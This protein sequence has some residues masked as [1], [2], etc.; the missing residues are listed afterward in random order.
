MTDDELISQ[1]SSWD[2]VI[3]HRA[4][5]R[6]NELVKERD[7]LR[8]FFNTNTLILGETE[9]QLEEAEAK[10]VKAMAAL[11]ALGNQK[12]SG[13]GPDS[14]MAYYA[15]EALEEIDGLK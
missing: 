6:I 7:K 4:A 3:A 10:L 14:L 11:T 8:E 1:L 12:T 2:A 9:I 15:R 5:D 13:G